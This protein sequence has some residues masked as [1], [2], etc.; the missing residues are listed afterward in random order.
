MA[1]LGRER[2][3]MATMNSAQAIV[4]VL[5]GNPH[6]SIWYRTVARMTRLDDPAALRILPL[7]F[8]LLTAEIV[9]S[10]GDQTHEDRFHVWARHEVARI[11]SQRLTHT[12][13][14]QWPTGVV[15]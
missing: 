15:G 6:V 3:V 2:Q 8:D 1:E 4:E 10:W 13:S 5:R 11:A 12:D 9:L 7:D 14:L